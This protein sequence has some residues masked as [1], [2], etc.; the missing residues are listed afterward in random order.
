MRSRFIRRCVLQRE[1]K[2]RTNLSTSRMDKASIDRIKNNKIIFILVKLIK[3]ILTIGQINKDK[4]KETGKSTNIY[5][6]EN[7][8][9]YKK[10]EDWRTMDKTLR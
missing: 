10:V 9:Q 8:K 3:T 6:L 2:I 7:L 1:I 5:V 4:I